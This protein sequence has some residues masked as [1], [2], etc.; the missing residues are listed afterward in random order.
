MKQ[1]GILH[2]EVQLMWDTYSGMLGK[3]VDVDH[4]RKVLRLIIG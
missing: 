4:C 1:Y 3:M 2:D